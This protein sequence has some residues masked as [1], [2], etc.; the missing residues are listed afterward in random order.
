MAQKHTCRSDYFLEPCSAKFGSRK[1]I[2]KHLPTQQRYSSK[3]KLNF[4]MKAI[5][6]MPPLQAPSKQYFKRIF[7][8]INILFN[9]QN[10]AIITNKSINKL[11]HLC[12]LLI[13]E[14]F[15]LHHRKRNIIFSLTNPGK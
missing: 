11:T 13:L 14:S 2:T 15:S 12:F 3:I 1:I 8:V 9:K 4:L 7:A 10:N 5:N 6:L